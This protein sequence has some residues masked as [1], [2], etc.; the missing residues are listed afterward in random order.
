MIRPPFADYLASW[1]LVPDGDV[2][3]T[4]TSML[5]PVRQQTIPAM[6]KIA[7]H[8]EEKQGNRLM[9]WWGG[10]GAARVLAHDDDGL[11]LERAV[12]KKA[13]ADFAQTG[14]DDE[15]S[16]ILCDVIAK[17]HAVRKAPTPDLVPLTRWF[18]DLEPAAAVNGGMLV[19]CA[20]V[21]RELLAAPADIVALHGD[22]HHGNVLDFGDRGWLAIDP[23]GLIGERGFDY[24]N[25]FCNPDHETATAPGRLERQVHVVADAAGLNRTRLLKW[26]VAW[27]G[28][29]AAWH[30]SEGGESPDTA[31]E[32]AARAVAALSD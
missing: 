27:A 20:E 31:L 18:R 12:G 1:D 23:K 15:A 30:I 32:V 21:A 11:L 9:M 26:I 19:R 17:L 25:I 28:L 3:V 10:Q 5:M 6:L 22:I 13:L 8:M 7:T 14:R 2:I 24:A 4:P 16:R 29:S